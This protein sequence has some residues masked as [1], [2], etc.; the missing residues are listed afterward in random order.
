MRTAEALRLCAP[1][2]RMR[3]VATAAP[4]PSSAE[5]RASNCEMLVKEPTMSSGEGMAKAEP[6][7]MRT[8][9]AVARRRMDADR[10]WSVAALATTHSPRITHSPAPGTD[11][12]PA[13]QQRSGAGRT[14][15][16]LNFLDFCNRKMNPGLVF[17]GRIGG[18]SGPS[19]DGFV[20]LYFNRMLA[21]IKERLL[22]FVTKYLRD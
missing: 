1:R 16:L 11:L 8:T 15:L 12:A 3:M 6:V 17:R 21:D 5:A 19:H 9:A 14:H 10:R 2:A 4:P 13:P 7:P 22:I 18:R 20:T